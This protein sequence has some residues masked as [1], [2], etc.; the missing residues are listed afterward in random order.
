MDVER[1]LTDLGLAQY[2]DAFLNNDID[3]DVLL[4]LKDEELQEIGVKSLG[5][6]KRLLRAINVLKNERPQSPSLDY[7][8]QVQSQ[9][10]ASAAERR[11]LT[12][13]FCDLVGSTSLAE[14][15]DPEDLRDVIRS[16]QDACAGVVS[17]FEGYVA[18]YVGDGILAYFGYPKAHEIGRAS[19]RE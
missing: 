13:M 1:W 9:V 18:K 7:Q 4:D 17:R 6:R 10:A 2:V 16:Y 12:V 8:A 15:L 3:Q 11:H 5:H 14:Q 19:C